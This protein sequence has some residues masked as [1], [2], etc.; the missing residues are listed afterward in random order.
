MGIFEIDGSKTDAFVNHFEKMMSINLTE[1]KITVII[2][3]LNGAATL[4]ELFA[5]LNRQ[6]VQ[7]D[8]ILVGDSSSTDESVR[9]C[10]D[11]GAR[12]LSYARENFDHGGTRSALV[13]EA[14]GDIV[15]FFT[16]D[17]IPVTRDALENLLRALLADEKTSC[18]YG[19]Q[20][21]QNNATPIASHLR[22]FNYP[23][24]SYV[25]SFKDK[26]KYGLKTIF[27]SNS[28]AAYKK[29]LLQKVGVFKNGLIFGED[30]CT[31]GKLLLDGYTVAYVA[32]AAVY[33][34][35]NYS[36]PEEF[37]RSFDIGV[38]H[39]SEQWLIDTYGSA[40]GVGAKYVRSVFTMLYKERKFF[41]M[42][43]CLLRNT[44]KMVGYKL[45]RSFTKIPATIRPYLSMHTVWWA[46]N[47]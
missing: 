15:V 5:A 39:S 33:H 27:I 13:Q 37:R 30:T 45:G 7:P 36:L 29:D 34:S 46:N 26:N 6:T 18:A 8:E 22:L 14:S 47:K 38:L 16:Q 12:V 43:D 35:H 42:I 41:Q 25:R 40:E 20:L 44:L 32:N 4:G 3:V 9:I 2:P 23:A 19:R 1:I 28:F 24:V 17:A 11:N 21:P 31:L 10:K